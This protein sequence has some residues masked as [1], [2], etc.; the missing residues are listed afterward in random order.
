VI[1]LFRSLRA[2]AIATVG[3]LA[4]IAC[5]SSPDK[6]KAKELPSLS[7]GSAYTLNP[8][9]S[10]RVGVVSTPLSIAVHADQVAVASSDGNLA[11]INASTG[12]DVW[13]VALNTPLQ[14]GVGT[15][16]NRFAVVSESNEVMAI[17][18][19]QVSWRFRLNA[20]TY[21][22][23]L[24]AGGRVF[25][26]TADRT[27]LAL[28]GATGQRLWSQQR[29]GDPLVLRQSGLLM[30][31]EDTLVAGLSGRLVGLNPNNGS[32]RWESIVG[33]SRGTNEVERLVDIVSGVSRQ[34]SVVCARSFQTSV[35]CVDAAKG[36]ALWSRSSNGHQGLSGDEE[37]LVGVDSDSKI[38][39]WNRLNGQT[40]WE[41]DVLR[42]R[43][44][45][46][47]LVISKSIVFGDEAGLL[48][49]LSL[50]DGKVQNRMGTDGSAIATRPVT[51]A[52]LVIAVTRN[53]GVYGYRL[54]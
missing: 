3:I 19:G 13:R 41:S 34:G 30:A 49:R 51:A 54:D 4:L 9:W 28:D 40:S 53:G 25:V 21:T 12:R 8:V 29:S 36:S 1:R 52:G 23:P 11:L 31:V 5:S 20:S 44:L 42:F 10:N 26:M 46:G 39:A 47:P 14:A 18:A 38:M 15:D 32:V 45:T 6:P 17:E 50:A 27:V 24:V 7:S 33:A 35:S 2:G 22:S 43:G 37:F 48:H 16:G